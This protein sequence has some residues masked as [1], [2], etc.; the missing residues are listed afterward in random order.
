MVFEKLVKVPMFGCAYER[1]ADAP[2]SATTLRD[3]R[4]EW[5]GLGVTKKLRGMALSAYD[6]FIGLEL[7]EA[8]DGCV[9]KAPR[10]GE[11]AG[12]SLVDRG[13]MGLKRSAAADA[14]GVSLGVDSASADRHDFPF[15]SPRRRRRSRRSAGRCPK[16]RTFT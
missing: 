1:I 11:K 8:A 9:T 6:R 10:G 14:S 5:I 13:K 7:R 3:R 4:D 2:C 15:W 12:K 16:R